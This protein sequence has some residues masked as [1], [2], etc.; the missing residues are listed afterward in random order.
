MS[1]QNLESC[2][3]CK[4]LKNDCRFRKENSHHILNE[5]WKNSTLSWKWGSDW[6]KCFEKR[7]KSM[8]ELILEQ[9]FLPK[10]LLQMITNYSV[11][12]WKDIEKG[13]LLEVQDA[14]KIYYGALII[15]MSKTAFHIR[16]LLWGS[17]WNEWI[18]KED[19]TKRC[20]PFYRI[21]YRENRI[22]LHPVIDIQ[23]L[24]D[25]LL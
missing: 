18:E 22:G 17:K 6:G 14:F 20:R 25:F 1:L 2:I 21:N 3:C 23:Y 15:D 24:R 19:I 16:F 10:D 8:S 4:L 5:E 7:Q 9:T 11:R 13:D 12:T